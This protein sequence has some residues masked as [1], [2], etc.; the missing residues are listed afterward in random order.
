MRVA[1]LANPAVVSESIANDPKTASQ[2][3]GMQNT[4]VPARPSG[5]AT[6]PSQETR[7]PNMPLICKK[8]NKKKTC[9]QLLRKS[10][11]P[12]GDRARGNNTILT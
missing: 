6:P 5:T 9:P 11:W 1:E 4:T 2:A 8:L 10:S 12:S 3:K 7:S